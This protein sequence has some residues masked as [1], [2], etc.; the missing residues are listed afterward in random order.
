VFQDGHAVQ[1]N[2]YDFALAN[3]RARGLSTSSACA[4]DPYGGYALSPDGTRGLCARGNQLTLF[5]PKRPQSRRVV[6]SDFG[7]SQGVDLGWIDNSHF[8]VLEHDGSCPGGVL[9]SYGYTRF[10]IFD[11]TGKRLSKGR[12]ALGI[13]AGNG[14][15]ALLGAAS[16]GFAWQLRSALASDYDGNDGY[17]R[18]H[19]AWSTDNGA[20]W[21]DGI[22]LTFDGNG[23]LLYYDVIS[24]VIRA[25]DGRVAFE[26][27]FSAEWS[28]R[29]WQNKTPIIMTHFKNT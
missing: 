14:K 28:N 16:N 18:H 13:V 26:D 25:E 3:D 24:Q 21:H 6:V 15:L 22:P 10:G 5:D 20:T 1:L 19:L 2:G 8:A 11:R 12:C 23:K 27:A 29:P 9:N 7:P 17:D 4:P